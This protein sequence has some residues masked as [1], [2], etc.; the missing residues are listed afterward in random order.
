M[1]GWFHPGSLNCSVVR[2]EG[3]EPRIFPTFQTAQ[4][5]LKFAKSASRFISGSQA[6]PPAATP[7]FRIPGS[8][9]SGQ[10]RAHGLVF[11]I[12]A[13][14]PRSATLVTWCSPRHFGAA[15]PKAAFGGA[16]K[17]E[18]STS[19]TGEWNSNPH[20]CPI[21][22]ATQALLQFGPECLALCIGLLSQ[23]VGDNASF[24]DSREHRIGSEGP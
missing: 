13:A 4:A 5:L 21:F 15:T 9:E 2:V 22:Q 1:P 7:P 18:I 10:R 19:L 17:G 20:I 23:S 8:I 24:P 11:P 6:N 16:N 3:I 12:R 14:L